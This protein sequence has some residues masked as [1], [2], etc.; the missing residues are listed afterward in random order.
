[1]GLLAEVVGGRDRGVAVQERQVAQI[2]DA[3]HVV[4]VVVDHADA[5]LVGVFDPLQRVPLELDVGH[6]EHG[7]HDRAHAVFAG[8]G[9]SVRRERADEAELHTRF[10]AAGQVADVESG[11]AESDHELEGARDGDVVGLVLVGEEAVEPEGL[12]LLHERALHFERHEGRFV[13]VLVEQRFHGF[14]HAVSDVVHSHVFNGPPEPGG[15][16]VG[17]FDELSQDGQGPVLVVEHHAVDVD[18]EHR[19]IAG[20]PVHGGVLAGALQHMVGTH[21]VV[22][23]RGL[24]HRI[25]ACGLNR[26][27]T[28][29]L[30]YTTVGK[31]GGRVIPGKRVKVNGSRKITLDN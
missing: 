14:F 25:L 28:L 7:L 9:E 4:R 3:V 10:V 11:P 22:A 19:L 29:S 30:L 16:V 13:G 21:D 18:P 31:R 6:R 5:A 15:S 23:V 27:R 2:V 24:V 1:M 8:Q 17:R 26:I 20:L 12:D